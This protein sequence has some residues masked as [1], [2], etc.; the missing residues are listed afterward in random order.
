VGPRGARPGQGSGRAELRLWRGLG[1]CAGC[2]RVVMDVAVRSGPGIFFDGTTGVRHA[3]SVEL[4]RDALLVRAAEG[5]LLACWDYGELEPLSAPEGM[6]R[7]GRLGSPV[8][9]RLEVHDAALAA[10][11]DQ[12]ATTVD[13]SGATERRSRT[14]VVLWSIAAVVSLVI[15]TIFGV[16]L[17]ADRL[18]PYV[19][20]SFE[21]R[22]GA[23]ADKQRRSMLDTDHKGERFECGGGAT[24][25]EGLAALKRLGSRLEPQ[26]S[27]KLPITLAVLR[28]SEANA[29][30]LPGGRI[31]VFD[32]LIKR[33]ETADEVAGVIAHE[34]GHVAH[35]DGTRS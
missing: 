2:R 21:R 30:A 5:H 11:I 26:A 4:D 35:R 32:G 14:K 18:T 29:I 33:A 9:A 6:L 19:P 34:I 13:R 12:M 15:V 20:L 16:P 24:E 22:L 8:L 31:Y 7:L 27:L 10:A 17:L 1:R 23:A 25:Q 28:K 3:V